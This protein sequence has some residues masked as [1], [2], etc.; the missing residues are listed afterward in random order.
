MLTCE[1]VTS[2]D[3]SRPRNWFFWFFCNDNF[4]MQSHSRTLSSLAR[5]D[6]LGYLSGSFVKL[7]N[8]KYIIEC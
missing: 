2:S 4:T 7:W 1:T 8:A 5:V 3:E 6:K